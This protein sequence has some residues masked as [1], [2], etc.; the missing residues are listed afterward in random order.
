[1]YLSTKTPALNK[2]KIGVLN[3]MPNKRKTEKDL[4]RVLTNPLLNV[5]LD[6]IYLETKKESKSLK[7]RYKSFNAIKNTYY[8]GMIITG[9]PLEHLNYEDVNFIKELKEF[10]D[11]TVKYVKSTIFLCWG[12]E[13]GLNYFYNVRSIKNNHKLSGVYK[14]KLVNK[15]NLVKGFSDT[16][17]VPTSRYYSVLE[18]DI[19]KNRN[20]KL[21]CKS[22]ISGPCIIE[23]KKQIF[24]LGHLEYHKNTLDK[25]YKRDLKK[26]LKPLKPENYYLNNKPINNWMSEATLLYHNWLYYFV[27]KE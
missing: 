16:F 27:F 20:L 7:K 23:G 12:A 17:L 18:S 5:D 21:I 25:E 14:H 13:F 6:F 19:L 26:G 22:N 3:L 24:I 4:V 9:A 2:V 8:D 11:Y 1:M 15:S 10:L